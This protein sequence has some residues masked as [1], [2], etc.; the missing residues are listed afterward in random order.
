ME[1]CSTLIG[2]VVLLCV[3]A[4]CLN[5]VAAGLHLII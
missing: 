2:C 1:E 5:V 3:G 4:D